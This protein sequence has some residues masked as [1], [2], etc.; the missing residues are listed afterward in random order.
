MKDSSRFSHSETNQLHITIV[1]ATINNQQ[2]IQKMRGKH[3]AKI[4]VQFSASTHSMLLV[5]DIYLE[6]SLPGQVRM[7]FTKSA[8]RAGFDIGGH[9]LILEDHC[10]QLKR[11]SLLFPT[12]ELF[13]WLR[14]PHLTV[15][16]NHHT[17]LFHHEWLSE[18]RQWCYPYHLE[19]TWCLPQ[20]FGRQISQ[21]TVS[22]MWPSFIAFLNRSHRS[23]H[24]LREIWL[25]LDC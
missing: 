15:W 18:Q 19:D 11:H 9:D 1:K 2:S 8:R 25:A 13:W 23:S 22:F 4:V 21:V 12:G 16:M 17:L 7:S 6:S 14:A 5:G 10:T 3:R 20:R 24:I